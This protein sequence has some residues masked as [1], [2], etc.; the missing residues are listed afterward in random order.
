MGL[1]LRAAVIVRRGV[2]GCKELHAV[3]SCT[4][5]LLIFLAWIVYI[6]SWYL[7]DSLS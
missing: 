3:P 6:K 4:R 1:K 7:L 2:A 5:C